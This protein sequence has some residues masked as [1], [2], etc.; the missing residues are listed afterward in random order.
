MAKKSGKWGPPPPGLKETEQGRVR[1]IAAGSERDTSQW[2][3][4]RSEDVSDE[5]HIKKVKR[6]RTETGIQLYLGMAQ[7]VE[8]EFNEDGSGGGVR[9][10]ILSK[11]RAEGPRNKC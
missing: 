2:F 3:G 11:A 4:R 9:G 5:H 7:D 6:V 8:N 1:C 10:W